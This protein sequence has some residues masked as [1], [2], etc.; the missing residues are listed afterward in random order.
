MTLRVRA[1]TSMLLALLVGA[2]LSAPAHAV[3]PKPTPVDNYSASLPAMTTNFYWSNLGSNAG[4]GVQAGEG[5]TDMAPAGS[6]SCVS[7]STVK[8][9]NT[10]WLR[11][12]GTGGRVQLSTAGSTFDTLLAVYDAQHALKCN[13]DAGTLQTSR[14]DLDTTKDQ[15]YYIQVGGC[16]GN[17]NCGASTGTIALTVVTNDERANALPLTNDLFTN[18]GAS[19]NG[20]SEPVSCTSNGRNNPYD[21]TVWFTWTAPAKGHVT[22]GASGAADTILTLFRGSST[23]A[24]QCNDDAGTQY[25]SRVGADVNGGETITLQ[26]G[27]YNNGS[28]VSVNNFSLEPIF[29]EDRDVDDDHYDKAP[30]PDCNDNDAGIHPTAVD[31]P[32]NGVDENCDGHDNIDADGDGHG[33]RSF[34]GDDCDDGNAARYPGATERLGNAVDENCDMIAQADEIRPAPKIS[35]GHVEV[36]GGRLF[37]TLKIAPLP[38]GAK[39]S[40]RCH[41]RGCPRRGSRQS[42]S[43]RRKGATVTFTQ[44]RGRTLR[45]GAW[46][47]ITVT[48]PRR[49]TNGTS[50]RYTVKR[51]LKVA[52]RTCTVKAL[53]GR[54]VGCRND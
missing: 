36:A 35:F 34:G 5:Y 45:P 29:D 54:K 13:D 12:N 9:T 38:A 18:V 53:S 46:V 37:G 52:H 42:K 49:N 20:A 11:F 50:E 47:E 24:E 14:L 48:L 10:A 22:I 30:G 2:A 1:T 16:T 21:A 32:K 3:G 17:D 39:V 40:V 19:S 25:S 28:N 51:S 8:M 44:F 31:V 33:D 7:G 6:S 27:G 4:F 15:A 43:A 41:G 23:T 26:V